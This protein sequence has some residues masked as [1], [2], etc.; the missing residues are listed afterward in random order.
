VASG[1]R[2]PFCHAAPWR[3]HRRSH[4]PRGL[5]RPDSRLEDG[6]RRFSQPQTA[7]RE[8]R[9]NGTVCERVNGRCGPYLKTK[10][11]SRPSQRTWVALGPRVGEASGAP[12]PLVGEQVRVR[13]SIRCCWCRARRARGARGP[14]APK[15]P[16]GR[17]TAVLHAHDNCGRLCRCACQPASVEQRLAPT[18]VGR[19]MGDLPA[20]RKQSRGLAGNSSR[21]LERAGTSHRGWT[22]ARRLSAT[23]ERGTAHARTQLT[24]AGAQ[25]SGS[26]PGTSR[27]T[28]YR[29][30]QSPRSS[31]CTRSSGSTTRRTPDRHLQPAGRAGRRWVRERCARP[32]A[33]HGRGRAVEGCGRRRGR[34]S[35]QGAGGEGR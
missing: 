31:P 19:P 7:E 9:E 14:R 34:R 24:R 10:I 13:R 1:P 21:G 26:A 20:T 25:G 16:R 18:S 4:G 12:C 3:L 17:A 28:R 23:T 30:P 33:D 15:A 11:A 2:P 8:R 6:H 29:P 32:R 5:D 27:S 35:P 22:R